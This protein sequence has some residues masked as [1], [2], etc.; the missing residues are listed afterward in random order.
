MSHIVGDPE[1]VRYALNRTMSPMM[2]MQYKE[3]LKVGGVIQRCL[4]EYCR[5]V[6][7]IK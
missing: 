6:N 2:V 4:E 5:F 1:V 3:Q 7:E